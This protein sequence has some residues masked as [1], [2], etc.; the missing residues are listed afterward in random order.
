MIVIKWKT[1]TVTT[2]NRKIIERGKIEHTNKYKLSGLVTGTSIRSGG[3]KLVV[4]ALTSPQ[5]FSTCKITV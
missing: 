3:A 5:V 1:E 2:F 4:W